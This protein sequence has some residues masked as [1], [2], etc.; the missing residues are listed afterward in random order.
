M[1]LDAIVVD[2]AYVVSDLHLAGWADA[3]VTEFFVALSLLPP[4]IP[5]EQIVGS[6]LAFEDQHRNSSPPRSS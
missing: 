3:E 6:H 5:L 2:E 4:P 1:D